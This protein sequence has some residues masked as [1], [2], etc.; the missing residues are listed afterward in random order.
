MAFLLEHG[1]I[2]GDQ[3]GVPEAAGGFFA[4][5]LGGL[6]V[7][8][9]GFVGAGGAE[10]VVDVYDLQNSRQYGNLRTGQAVGIAGTVGMFVM[11]ADDGEN[12]TQGMQRAAGRRTRAI[13]GTF[14]VAA[15]SRLPK[16]AAAM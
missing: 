4:H 10:R 1:E 6:F 5:G 8:E 2:L 14:P 12:E 3:F 7:G 13:A 11:V 16:K 9:R 15:T